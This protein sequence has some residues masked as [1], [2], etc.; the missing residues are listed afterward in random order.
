[1]TS[2]N[3]RKHSKSD[4]GEGLRKDL[5]DKQSDILLPPVLTEIALQ[6]T[7]IIASITQISKSFKIVANNSQR[8]VFSK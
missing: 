8:V 3:K 6:L 1:M 5:V 2:D 7:K 4:L